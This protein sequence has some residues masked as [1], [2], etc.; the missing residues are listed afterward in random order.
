MVRTLYVIVK[1]GGSIAFKSVVS[2][3]SFDHTSYQQSICVSSV[4]YGTARQRIY[5][6]HAS[7][8]TLMTDD[9]TSHPR[10]WSSVSHPSL[11][12]IVRFI[13]HTSCCWDSSR[14]DKINDSGRSAN[15]NRNR[16]CELC[17]LY[18]T[19]LSYS[20]YLSS[21]VMLCQLWMG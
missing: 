17:Q 21:M 19:Q 1:K 12:V 14:Y 18:Y 8:H 5:H 6:A 10:N 16:K 15:T 7:Q 3:C 2:R 20:Q 13:S 4:V 11:C 9:V